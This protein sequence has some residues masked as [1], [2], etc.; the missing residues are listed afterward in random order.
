[1]S[2][3]I[4]INVKKKP[5]RN[6]S[7]GGSD[8]TRIMRGDGLELWQEKIGLKNPDNLSDVLSVQIGIATER[9]NLDW[10]EKDIE[11][12][13]TRNVCVE[14]KNY[15]TSNLDG[16]VESENMCAE[17]KHTYENNTLEKV[18]ETNFAQ[19]QHYMMHS[20]TD[21]MYVSAIFGN[22]RW[23]KTVIHRDPEYIKKL[24][25]VLDYFWECVK[26]KTEPS[27]LGSFKTVE[28]LPVEI[29]MDGMTKKDMNNHADWKEFTRQLKVNKPHVDHYE[30]CKVAL[31]DMVPE[32]CYEASGDGVIVTQKWNK[33]YNKYVKTLKIKETNN[34][35]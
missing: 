25:A 1:M 32:D 14:P 30:S 22:R 9:V 4:P 2:K 7:M 18:I 16:Y 35:E 11:Q 19:L 23:E 5:D 24:I 6:L 33:R 20:D 10:L 13:I 28:A 27:K 21:S 8:S 29:P 26:T 12:D 15:L 17:A 31:K 3:I 34:G